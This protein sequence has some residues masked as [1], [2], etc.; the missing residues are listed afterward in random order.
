MTYFVD[1]L[2]FVDFNFDF[3]ELFLEFNIE[4]CLTSFLIDRYYV[5]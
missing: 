4:T 3:S 1:K 5:N 2:L